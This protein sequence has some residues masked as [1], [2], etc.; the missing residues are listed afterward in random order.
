VA[1]ESVVDE[2][3]GAKEEVALPIADELTVEADVHEEET[4]P[5]LPSS[6]GD[7]VEEAAITSSPDI[8]TVVENSDPVVQENY[9][10]TN[11]SSEEKLSAAHYTPKH[12]PPRQ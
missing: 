6:G 1:Q 4:P 3:V 8:A 11:A 9:P 10:E 5:A 2:T 7:A 12:I